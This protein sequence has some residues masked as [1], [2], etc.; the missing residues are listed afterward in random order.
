MRETVT[1]NRHHDLPAEV[2]ATF[3]D[4]RLRHSSGLYRHE[5]VPL[6]DAQ[7]AKLHFVAERLAVTKG[8]RVLDIGCGWGSL[9]LF[10][11]KEY[12]CRVTGITPSRTQAA[13]VARLAEQLGVH[14]RVEVR[15]GSFVESE[16]AGRFDAVAM[17][18][19]I[20]HMPDRTRALR[21]AHRLLRREGTF[22]LSESC[23]RN[24]AAQREFAQQVT[25]VAC[26]FEDMV[27]LSALVES[28]EVAGFSVTG[29]TDLTAHYQRT[30]GDW[31]SRAVANQVVIDR[32]A[33][34]LSARLIRQLGFATAEWGHT[35]KHYA[36]TA[37]KSRLGPQVPRR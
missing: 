18:G 11:V 4:R 14:D 19:S 29:L 6:D 15:V 17:L 36:L 7:T 10:L 1:T 28:V 20:L 2:F 3:L 32:I 33:P 21:K 34:G 35:T 13:Y 12:G 26:G 24:E 16:V 22:Y 30:T 37:S 5:N 31:E 8:A 27:P 25:D 23:F 9:V